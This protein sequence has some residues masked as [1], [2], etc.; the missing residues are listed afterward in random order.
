MNDQNQNQ[1]INASALAPEH[2]PLLSAINGLINDALSETVRVSAVRS[3]LGPDALIPY[4]DF[5]KA[6]SI[7]YD[8]GK[9][10]RNEGRLKVLEVGGKLMVRKGHV[11]EFVRQLPL[12]N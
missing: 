5:L 4:G 2:Q 7:S 11:S 10:L 12:A 3:A 8:L 6:N 1:T 9:R